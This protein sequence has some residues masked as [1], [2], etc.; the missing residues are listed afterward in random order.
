MENIS[1]K[2][3]HT[4]T[5]H[6]LIVETPVVT[7][8]H[9]EALSVETCCILCANKR[10]LSHLRGKVSLKL[11]SE[12]QFWTFEAPILPSKIIYELQM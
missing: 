8:L 4:K 1:I 2:I 3:I 12:L 11:K 6:H 5:P 9:S 10:S 7:C